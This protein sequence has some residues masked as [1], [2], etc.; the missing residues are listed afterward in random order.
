MT[1]R[2]DIELLVLV[3]TAATA[4]AV[5]R[6]ADTATAVHLKTVATDLK[7]PVALAF[8]PGDDSHVYVGERRGLI[9]EV[10]LSG[11]ARPILDLTRRITKVGDNN[12]RGLL[13]L[14][15]APDF[16]QSRRFYVSYTTAQGDVNLR[17]F[18]L[19]EPRATKER[20]L[21]TV[22]QRPFH[23]W[24]FAGDLHFDQEGRLLVST[25][26]GGYWRQP[27]GTSAPKN[28]P[29]D[30]D[31]FGNSQNVHVANAKLLRFD[32][33]TAPPTYSIVAY[34]L[35]NP[36]R[37]SIDSATGDIWIGDVGL[38]RA[39]EVDVVRANDPLLNFGWSVYEGRRKR[40][41]CGVPPPLDTTGRL[42]WP[43]TSYNHAHGDCAIIGG[44]VYRGNTIPSLRG[45]YLFGDD[46]SG[47]IWS[48]DSARPSRARLEPVRIPGLTS[49]AAD[50]TG[51]V[52]ATSLRG[53]LYEIV[54]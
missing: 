48:I 35:R 31:P 8:A 49:F 44:K 15:L 21:L 41:Y 1:R 32:L 10:S 4:T 54:R 42:T 9:Q 3:A 25:G 2:F 37:F 39:E 14:V 28:R 18:V 17:Q 33:S 5:S 47:R 40:D 22:S 20:L 52:Y 43:F 7:A 13:G 46:C 24:H 53:Q 19:G 6:P 51:N 34:G 45:R 16:A 11:R 27:L 30:G 29:L 12:E 23:L 26:D 38:D 50:N 36:W